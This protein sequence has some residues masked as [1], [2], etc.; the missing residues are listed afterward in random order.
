MKN[1]MLAAACVLLSCTA[2]AKKVKFAVN[3]SAQV[4]D[5]GGVHI[6][7]DFQS[8]AGFPGG[9]WITDSTPM[10]Q[11]QNDTNIY[12]VVV[13]IPAF[14]CYQFKFVNG[15]HGY[16]QE[17]VPLESRVNYNFLDSRWIYIDSLSNDTQLV[18]PIM[19]AANAPIGKYLMRF[20]V[21]MSLVTVNS[22]GAHVAGLFQG[23]NPATTRLYSFDNVVYEYIA[24]V[25]TGI[26]S[27]QHEYKFLN[28]NTNGDLEILPGWCASQAGNRQTTVPK[29]TMLPTICYNYCSTCATIGIDEVT[30]APSFNMYPNPSADVINI[31]FSDNKLIHH[32]RITD[33]NGRLVNEARNY[34][35]DTARLPVEALQHGVYFVT[36]SSD[37]GT[38]TVQKLIRE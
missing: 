34:V 1:V 8:E 22:N 28:G 31:R 6:A 38:R 7:G 16:N 11:D 14:T 32:I 35:Y 3:M 17:F 23:W 33:V 13:D 12:T 21:D 26:N 4:I 30:A 27:F 20:Y 15:I 5:T 24:Y 29:D 36:V 18:G 9:D 37:D 25:D 19:Y 2:F 10:T